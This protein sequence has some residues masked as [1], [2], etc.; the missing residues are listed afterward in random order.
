MGRRPPSSRTLGLTSALTDA[1]ENPP[2]PVRFA[3]GRDGAWESE[4]FLAKSDAGRFRRDVDLAGQLWPDGWVKGVGYAVPARD[5]PVP[6]S[7]VAFARG[8]VRDLTGITPATRHR[9]DRQVLLVAEQ[10]RGVLHAEAT[11]A[12]IEQTHIRRWVNARESAG[13]RPKTIANYHGLLFMVLASASR[14]G[15]R[16]GNPCKGTRLPDRHSPDADADADGGGEVVFLTEL[17]FAAT[18]EAMF[19]AGDLAEPPEQRPGR[20]LHV[21]ARLVRHRPPPPPP[22][23]PC[24]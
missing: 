9:D 2:G 21:A 11:A 10:L 22:H 20:L 16:V 12:Y 13:G 23:R 15:L 6:P 24:R 1:S 8:Y 7:F 4:T 3:R 18:A 5:E 17:Q 19:P 14:A